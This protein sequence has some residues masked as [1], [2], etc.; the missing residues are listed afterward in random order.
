[1]TQL[2]RSIAE[3]RTLQQPLYGHTSEDTAY[4]VDDYPYGFREL[5]RASRAQSRS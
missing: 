5:A 3:A 2:D 1:M 4:L